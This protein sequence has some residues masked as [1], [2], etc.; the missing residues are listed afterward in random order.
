MSDEQ[1]RICELTYALGL[2]TGALELINLVP[3]DFNKDGVAMVL[4]KLKTLT[5][6]AI[7]F[8]TPKSDLE[9]KMKSN[10]EQRRRE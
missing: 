10:K 8:E 9:S 4:K 2:A 6:A 5:E 3:Y 7:V 1:K